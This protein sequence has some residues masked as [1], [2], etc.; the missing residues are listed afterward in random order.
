VWLEVRGPNETNTRYATIYNWTTPQDEDPF[1]SIFTQTGEPGA[2]IMANWLL[3]VERSN[4]EP[5][6]P[7]GSTCV[8]LATEET[9]GLPGTEANN[10]WTV[11]G[12]V[13]DCYANATGFISVGAANLPYGATDNR[14][15]GLRFQNVAIPQ[16]ATIRAAY[17]RYIAAAADAGQDMNADIHGQLA[18]SAG[19][20]TTWENFQAR[21]RTGASMPWNSIPAHVLGNA[22]DTPDLSTIVQEIVDQSGWASGQNMVF[23]IANDDSTAGADR[24]VSGVA[25][26]TY[27]PAVLYVWWYTAD[28]T[29]GRDET[30]VNENYIANKHNQA[31]LTHIFVDNGGVFGP[32]LLAGNPPYDLLPAAPV[33][34]DAIYF[35]SDV[36]GATSGPFGSLI[37]DLSAPFVDPLGACIWEYH[38][39]IGPWVALTPRQDETAAVWGNGLEALGVGGVFWDQNLGTA[40]TTVAVNGITAWWVRARANGLVG[41]ATPPTQQNRH[42]YTLN[43]PDVKLSAD[44]VAG[45]I[46]AL[47]RTKLFNRSAGWNGATPALG[48]NR[49]FTAIRSESRG[50]NFRL[51]VNLA[52]EQNLAGIAVK[53]PPATVTFVNDVTATTGRCVLYNPV[54][55]DAMADVCYVEFDKI[56]ADHYYGSFHAFLRLRQV[57]GSAGDFEVR[58]SVRTKAGGLLFQSDTYTLDPIPA[59][60]ADQER[61][62]LFDAGPIN[63]VPSQFLASSDQLNEIQIAIGLSNANATPGDL[64]LMDLALLPVDEWASDSEDYT[65]GLAGLLAREVSDQLRYLDID[66]IGNP[67]YIKRCLLRREDT[68]DSINAL[69]VFRSNGPSILQANADQRIYVLMAR[70]FASGGEDFWESNPSCSTTVQSFSR[71]RYM[72]GR[73]AR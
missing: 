25:H 4:W 17:I 15:V 73:G 35:G 39:G 34:N 70:H 45:D 28:H 62:L 32:N 16:G 1:G 54:G 10:N 3:M 12:A 7:T 27:N 43:W 8:E 49:T 37:F 20:F 58:L 55:V 6:A 30:C 36:T 18:A 21:V 46:P 72:S 41:P 48:A 19:A 47:S 66:S 23:F 24:V 2:V 31:Q 13:S 29:M 50:T 9:Y 56:I 65:F 33:T 26:A 59:A 64:R 68:E 52:D 14:T 67:R 57:G 40:W 69:W 22:Y 42:V 60:G 53:T 38:D 51:F 61:W 63:L 5:S 44:Q 71:A 11:A